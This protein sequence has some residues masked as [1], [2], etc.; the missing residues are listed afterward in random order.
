M[1]KV[2]DQ[3]IENN[4]RDYDTLFKRASEYYKHDAYNEALQDVNNALRYMPSDDHALRYQ[5]LM[6]RANIY[7]MSHR[8]KDRKSVV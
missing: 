2:Y 7:D 8:Y 4:P 6:L 1:M 3:T 5:A